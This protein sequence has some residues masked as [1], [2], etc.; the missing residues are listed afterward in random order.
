MTGGWAWLLEYAT[1]VNGRRHSA[2]GNDIV[3]IV[4]RQLRATQ[5]HELT[6]Q[7]EHNGKLLV[8]GVMGGLKMQ[9]WTLTE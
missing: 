3:N 4:K 9:E 5:K 7:L 8:S 6:K 2:A 1:P